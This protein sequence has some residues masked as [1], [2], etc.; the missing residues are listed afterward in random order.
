M[1]CSPDLDI[2]PKGPAKTHG[3]YGV[4]KELVMENGE[5]RYDLKTQP[6]STPIVQD[7]GAENSAIGFASYFFSS[8]RTRPLAL[9]ANDTGQI[10][11][12]SCR[13]RVLQ[14]V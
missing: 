2:A 6:V 5:F 12:A 11:R 3:M 13:E 1:L 9:S 8:R 14:V 4:F 10:G 7:I